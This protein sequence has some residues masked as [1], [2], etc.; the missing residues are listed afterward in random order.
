MIDTME[1]KSKRQ[2]NQVPC[3]NCISLPCC[4]AKLKEVVE[5]CGIISIYELACNCSI[6]ETYILPLAR[7][8][9]KYIKSIK[10]DELV[11]KLTIKESTRC[12]YRIRRMRAF[13]SVIIRDFLPKAIK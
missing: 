5:E 3:R 9:V 2:Y 8:K 11:R 6:A 12:S 10:T 4:I 7:H 13:F 1:S